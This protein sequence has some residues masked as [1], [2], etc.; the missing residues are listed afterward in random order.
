MTVKDVPLGHLFYLGESLFRK[1]AKYIGAA[2]AVHLDGPTPISHM[3]SV[4]T[5]R[6]CYVMV[7][8]LEVDYDALVG[9]LD[10]MSCTS[11]STR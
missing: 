11:S 2:G 5:T 9:A 1:N 8:E 4:T 10:T 6:R 7:N 3:I